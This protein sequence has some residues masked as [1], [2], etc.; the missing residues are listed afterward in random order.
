MTEIACRSCSLPENSEKAL[1][2]LAGGCVLEVVQLARKGDLSDWV[3]LME[4]VEA[5]CPGQRPSRDGI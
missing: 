5:L 4:V 1:E 3:E 2:F